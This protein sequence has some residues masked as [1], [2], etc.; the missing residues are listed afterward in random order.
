MHVIANAK[1]NDALKCNLL[2]SLFHTYLK[3]FVYISSLA[4]LPFTNWIKT[5]FRSYKNVTT[6]MMALALALVG[7]RAIVPPD[8]ITR[9]EQE[10]FS[11]YQP[12][13]L[14]ITDQ[15]WPHLDTDLILDRA[16]YS[17]SKGADSKQLTETLQLRSSCVI[18][19][20]T[21]SNERTSD[22]LFL[23]SVTYERPESAFLLLKTSPDADGH[24]HCSMEDWNTAKVNFVVDMTKAKVSD[25]M[26]VCRQN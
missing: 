17:I 23:E 26:S 6:M 10:V 21:T 12:C 13:D 15:A 3:R 14:V 11:D 4:L 18:L 8:L 1:V 7:A 9:I 19:V 16:W 5:M 20:A 25:C 22:K 24:N 2:E